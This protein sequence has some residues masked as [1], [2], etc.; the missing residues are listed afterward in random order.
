MKRGVAIFTKACF[1]HPSPSKRQKLN[2]TAYSFGAPAVL[3]TY[4]FA[5]PSYTRRWL[6]TTPSMTGRRFRE[7]FYFVS[8]FA[9]ATIPT[10]QRTS[11]TGGYQP[12]RSLSMAGSVSI[13][14]PN[15]NF[16]TYKIYIKKSQKKTS[17][18]CKSHYFTW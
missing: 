16:L 17:K 15:K 1:G 9:S 6:R 2:A 12:S 8:T 7:T 13:S 3:R 14:L 11:P 10:K 5:T 18:S 4:H